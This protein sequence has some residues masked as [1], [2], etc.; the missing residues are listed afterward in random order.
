[1]K[2]L[3]KTVAIRRG[4]LA[5]QLTG[6]FEEPRYVETLTLIVP[7]VIYDRLPENMKSLVTRRQPIPPDPTK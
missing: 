1:M 3:T 4:G 2:P 5:A 6:K 7:P